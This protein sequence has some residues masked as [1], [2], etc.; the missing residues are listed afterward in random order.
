MLPYPGTTT[1]SPIEK[2]LSEDRKR[3]RNVLSCLD[4]RRRKLK[5]DRAFPVC[6][7]CQRGGNAASCTYQSPVNG[8]ERGSG[9][10][11]DGSVDLGQRH[12]KKQRISYHQPNGFATSQNGS[13]IDVS[14]PSNSALVAQEK[15]IKRLEAR[16]ADLERIVDRGSMARDIADELS[17]KSPGR[18]TET[19]IFRGKG[20]KTQF[21]GAT[22][23]INQLA[24]VIL[25]LSY[26]ISVAHNSSFLRS[27]LL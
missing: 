10:E 13:L 23:P 5:C 9:T 7:R 19:Y 17:L 18:E 1:I 3:K 8:D 24:H 11:V 15:T 14:S 26:F 21:Y 25:F 22:L 12:E 4:C 20:F 2:A 16:L 27:G 6:G